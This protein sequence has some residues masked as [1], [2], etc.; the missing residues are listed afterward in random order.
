M[1]V[2]AIK[3]KMGEKQLFIKFDFMTFEKSMHACIYAYVLLYFLLW[4]IFWILHYFKLSIYFVKLGKASFRRKS[5]VICKGM[6][7]FFINYS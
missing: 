1:V 5:E 3:K 7:S 6:A 4:V 2:K